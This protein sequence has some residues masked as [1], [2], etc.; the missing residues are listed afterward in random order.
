MNY[1]PDR[2]INYVL[3]YDIDGRNAAVKIPA[4]I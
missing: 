3:N 2:A 4:L 1:T